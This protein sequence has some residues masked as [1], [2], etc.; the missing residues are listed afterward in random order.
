[1]RRS[2]RA[3]G[4]LRGHQIARDAVL[5]H[6]R[7]TPHG[8]AHRRDGTPPWPRATPSESTRPCTS[9]R[10]KTSIA[11][12][13][14]GTSSRARRKTTRSRMPR[15][16]ACASR[17]SL[18]RTLAHDEEAR[19]RHPVGHQRGRLQERLVVLL[20]AERRDDADHQVVLVESQGGPEARAS[21]PRRTLRGRRRCGSHAPCAQDGAARASGSRPDAGRHRSR[22]PSPA[23]GRGRTVSVGALGARC[24][25]SCAPTPPCGA[26]GR[27]RRPSG[28]AALRCS[29][30][31][32]RH[33]ARWPADSET[34]SRRAPAACFLVLPSAVP[35]TSASSR[36]V[37]SSP[38]RPMQ[39]TRGSMTDLSRRDTSVVT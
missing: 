29:H 11:A 6:L 17:A 26:R 24:R 23:P 10:V 25:R 13:T 33:R 8:R 5:D 28:R 4:A 34:R 14:A 16:A 36:W 2:A 18:R 37:N 31:R 1:M 27:P 22:R 38:R 21:G 12:S 39:I 35:G 7:D 19:R 15:R 30:A 20:G 3:A 32:R 9:E